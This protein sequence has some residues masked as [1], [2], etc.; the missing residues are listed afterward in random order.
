MENEKH[1]NEFQR[2]C[3]TLCT[4]YAT[5]AKKDVKTNLHK[6]TIDKDANLSDT[7]NLPYSLKLGEELRVML[8]KNIDIS[9]CLKNRAIGNT[10]EFH[11]R[12]SSTNQLGVIF[13]RFDNSVTVAHAMT[14]HKSQWSTIAYLTGGMNQSTKNPKYQRKTDEDLFYTPLSCATTNDLVKIVNFTEDVI[15][16]NKQ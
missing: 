3:L 13:V 16:C 5:D 6:I 12:A 10:V 7:G 4:I 1:L 14:V 15:K 8:A 2:E 11:R 9:D